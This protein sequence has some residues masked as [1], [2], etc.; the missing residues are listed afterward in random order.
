MTRRLKEW[1]SLD[2][3]SDKKTKALYL[4]MIN[5]LLVESDKS[6]KAT[7]KV[8]CVDQLSRWLE[9]DKKEKEGKA[10]TSPGK[11]S[12]A[13]KG[14]GAAASAA[15]GGARD[16]VPDWLT[17]NLTP[18]PK[19]GAE[20]AADNAP[21]LRAG[22]KRGAVKVATIVQKQLGNYYNFVVTPGEQNLDMATPESVENLDES[23]LKNQIHQQ[24]LRVT[25]T[26][27]G[28]DPAQVEKDLKAKVNN[29]KINMTQQIQG[30]L[31]AKDLMGIP[32]YVYWA[33]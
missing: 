5:Y 15:A 11:P 14:G 18:T 10:K 4:K 23:L 3:K 8:K 20:A 7:G 19:K 6:G 22:L 25:K 32:D 12:A 27:Q 29:Y 31:R 28:S 21:D 17:K 1:E 2:F 30:K 26:Y 33:E 13:R 16:G 9:E 24:F